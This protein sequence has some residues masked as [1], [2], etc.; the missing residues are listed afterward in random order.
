MEIFG[1]VKGL[2]ERNLNV[3]F[4]QVVSYAVGRG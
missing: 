4:F 1:I 2:E 3:I